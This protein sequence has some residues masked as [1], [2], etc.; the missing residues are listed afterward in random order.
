MIAKEWR[1]ARWKLA[2]GV[3]A[4][5]VIVAVAP[6]TYEGILHDT[7]QMI[8][9]SKRDLRSLGVP[10]VPP[11]TPEE[12]QPRNYGEQLRR[13]VERMQR[14]EYPAKVAGWEVEYTQSL[15][16]YGILIPL[17]GLLG[18]ALVSTEV[19]RNSIYVLLS[20]PVSRSRVLL[21]KYCVCAGCLLAV[22]VVGAVG[23]VVSAYAHGYPSGAV[24]IGGIMGSAALI[25]LGSLFVLGVALLASV[26]FRDVIRTLIAT[27]AT[28]CLVFSG[29]DLVR[30]AIEGLFWT[31]SDYGQSFR[32]ETAWDNTFETFRLSNYWGNFYPY[33]GDATVAQSFLVCLLTAV[34][35]L[36]LAPWLFDRKAY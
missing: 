4:F 30:G 19:S 8:G 22:A 7:E 12:M 15:G 11:G 13:D 24:D 3:L 20:K 31:N 9:E 32:E 28:I 14:P 6:R 23:M 36:L 10:G 27:V 17:A 21:I 34:P 25:W 33:S 16:N 2:I 5:L 1:D 18:A 26:I 29:P 35:P